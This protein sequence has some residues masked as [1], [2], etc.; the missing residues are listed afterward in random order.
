ML[1]I[2]WFGVLFIAIV[3][4]NVVVAVILLIV[5]IEPKISDIKLAL[6]YILAAAPLGGYAWYNVIYNAPFSIVVGG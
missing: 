2:G 4:T 3:C 6:F 1:I 5:Y